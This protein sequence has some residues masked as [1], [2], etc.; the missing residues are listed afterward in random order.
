MKKTRVAVVG[1][2]NVGKCALDT[3]LTEPDMELGGIIEVP[4][5]ISKN[6][7]RD[8]RDP[9]PLPHIPMVSDIKELDAIDVAILSCPSRVVRETAVKILSRGV[10]TVDSFDIHT[11][12]PALR[13]ELDVIAKAHKS[14][15]KIG[16]AHV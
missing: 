9:K 4:Q 5:V 8:D 14:V 1:Y 10:R 11:E 12:I 2:G 7:P 6:C 16:R 3:V 15:A 13:K